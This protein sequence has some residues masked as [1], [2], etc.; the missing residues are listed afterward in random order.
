L[1]FTPG[2]IVEIDE[3]YT[4]YNTG[5]GK[6]IRLKRGKGSQRTHGVLV[7]TER[8]GISRALIYDK[9][10]RG[11]IKRIIKSLLKKEDGHIICTDENPEYNFLNSEQYIRLKVKHR[12]K[13]FAKG[14]I[15]N[16]INVNVHVN[17]AEEINSKIQHTINYVHKG[18]YP[19]YLQLYISRIIFAE[20]IKGKSFVE[21]FEMLINALP[22]FN[23]RAKI[24]YNVAK[25][26][27]MNDIKKAA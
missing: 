1:K 9:N 19:E 17:S 14:E 3:V 16:D 4:R 5:F 8:G 18:V 27:Y 22:S 15:A 6:Y 21:A 20:N 23:E 11:E 12:D 13:E 26:V 7:I 10:K 24:T 2:S 25:E